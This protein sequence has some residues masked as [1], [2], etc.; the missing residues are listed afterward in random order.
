MNG[1][2]SDLLKAGRK[3]LRGDGLQTKLRSEQTNFQHISSDFAYGFCLARYHNVYGHAG[4]VPGFSSFIGW[5]PESDMIIGVITNLSN[6]SDKSSPAYELAKA[7]LE[8]NA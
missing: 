2:M 8:N 1:R 5:L 6:F 3:A 4:D 7:I